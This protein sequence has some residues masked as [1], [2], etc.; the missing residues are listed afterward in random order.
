MQL[1]GCLKPG[2][3]G[4]LGDRFI[5]LLLGFSQL[6]IVACLAH[7]GSWLTYLS[8]PCLSEQSFLKLDETI[9]IQM[10]CPE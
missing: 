1:L 6:D 5:C 10:A 4:T 2:P 3:R 7:V 9:L 8:D